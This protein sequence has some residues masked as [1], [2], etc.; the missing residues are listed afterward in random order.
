M[1]KSKPVVQHLITAVVCIVLGGAAV[2]FELIPGGGS[3]SPQAAISAPAP[4]G[5]EAALRQMQDHERRLENTEAQ[6][7]ALMDSRAEDN[8]ALARQLGE[9]TATVLAIRETLARIDNTL[10]VGTR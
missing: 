4:I 5:Y 3:N 8:A 1:T 7:L 10:A 6:I 9:L 2:R